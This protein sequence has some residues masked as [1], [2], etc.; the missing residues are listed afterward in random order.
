MANG[1]D[2][3]PSRS[4]VGGG[5]GVDWFMKAFVEQFLFPVA[6]TAAGA[7]VQRA[8][9]PSP[10]DMPSFSMP[11]APP[12]AKAPVIPE[13]KPTVQDVGAKAAEAEARARTVD[14]KRGRKKG[15]AGTR[16]IGQPLGAP[17]TGNSGVQL[18]GQ[19]RP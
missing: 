13:Q 14:A 9:M 4:N 16:A 11:S 7:A 17:L 6:A 1:F 18:L 2:P 12:Q 19:G 5:S 10:P 8:I 15:R 3:G